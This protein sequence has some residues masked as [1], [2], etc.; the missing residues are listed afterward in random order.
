MENMGAFQEFINKVNESRL[1]TEDE[2]KLRELDEMQ[3]S[4]RHA[5]QMMRVGREEARKALVD[6]GFPEDIAEEMALDMV[7]TGIRGA[8]GQG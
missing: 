7:R 8:S 1:E 6:E 2:K 5:A 4:M 3:K